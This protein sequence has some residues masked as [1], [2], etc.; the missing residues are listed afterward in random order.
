MNVRRLL[1]LQQCTSW[2]DYPTAEVKYFKQRFY[3]YNVRYQKLQQVFEV[4]SFGLN[5]GPKLFLPQVHCPVD[6]TLSQVSPEIRLLL[7]LRS[8][9]KS[10]FYCSQLRNERGLSL[11]KIISKCRELVKLC[12][13]NSRGLDFIA[14]RVCT[15]RTMPWQDVCPSVRLSVTH[16]YSVKTAEHIII[17]CFT[18][19]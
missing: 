15:V 4:L 3:R 5:A 11:P 14:R 6:D 18:I 9:L 2:S 16:Q 13:I 8:K 10:F 1:C 7:L 17:V 12:H 19:E